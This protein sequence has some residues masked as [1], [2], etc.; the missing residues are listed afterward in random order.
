MIK[1]LTCNERAKVSRAVS[2]HKRAQR[3]TH[4]L[5]VLAREE[6]RDGA[7]DALTIEEDLR[8]L[9]LG[10]RE[11]VVERRLRVELDALLR[12]TAVHLRQFRRASTTG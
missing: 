12:R 3:G 4:P 9:Q 2:L 11:D 1:P 6:D 7:A 5:S 8:L 10:V